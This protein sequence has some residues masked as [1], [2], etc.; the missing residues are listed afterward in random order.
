MLM[1]IME[2][3]EKL[4]ETKS[5]DEKKKLED[6][7]FHSFQEHEKAFRCSLCKSGYYGWLWLLEEMDKLCDEAVAMKYYDN[8]I[9]EIQ[10]TNI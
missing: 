5:K 1:E 6:Q 3:R 9:K 4:S 7:V 8:I 10:G 2:I